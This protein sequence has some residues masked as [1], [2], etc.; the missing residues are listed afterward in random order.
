MQSDNSSLVGSLSSSSYALVADIFG[1]LTVGL[2]SSLSV[3]S[4]K[5]CNFAYL[6]RNFW[7][8]S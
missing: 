8:D 6:S 3:G 1:F 4:L 2:S 7:D 5:P